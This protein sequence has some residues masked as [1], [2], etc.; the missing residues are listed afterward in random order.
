MEKSYKGTGT[1]NNAGNYGFILPVIDGQINGGGGQDKFRIKIWDKATGNIIYDNQLGSA[2]NENPTTAI[3]GGTTQTYS[4]PFPI[5]GS[6]NHAVTY[7]ATRF[8]YKN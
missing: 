3:D 2:D 8:S 7:F 4:V 6:G 1:N 5:S